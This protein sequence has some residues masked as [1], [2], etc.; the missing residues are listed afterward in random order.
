MKIN[1]LNFKGALLLALL[2]SIAF[3]ALISG[4]IG[5]SHDSLIYLE[6]AQNII[7]GNGFFVNGL[8]MTHYPP[9]YP[10]LLS[11]GKLSELNPFEFSEYVQ[12]LLFGLNII[13]LA[14][15]VYQATMK[16]IYYS[17]LGALFFILSGNVLTVFSYVWSEALFVF[18]MLAGNVFM[19]KYLQKPRVYL[20]I[21]S[22]IIL[23]LTP[24]T[25]YAGFV[26]LI[27]SLCLL[28]VFWGKSIFFRRIPEFILYIVF[29]ILPYSVW[30]ARNRFIGIKERGF[31]PDYISI[32]TLRNIVN[33]I[34][35][36]LFGF[37]F[38]F[39]YKFLLLSLIATLIVISL[40]LICIKLFF[41]LDLNYKIT[42]Y[43]LLLCIISVPV[44]ISFIIFARIFFDHAIPFDY[45]MFFPIYP[46]IIIALLT[47]FYHLTEMLRQ[48]YIKVLIF[49]V[50]VSIFIPGFTNALAY[51]KEVYQFGLGY[52]SIKSE[53]IKALRN[54]KKEIKIYSTSGPAIGLIISREVTSFP[55]KYEFKEKEI[56][57]LPADAYSGKIN[58]LLK[59]CAEGKAV[60]LYLNNFNWRCSIY[61]LPSDV[62]IE[63]GNLDQIKYNDGIILYSKK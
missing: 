39:R 31:N 3:F 53:A 61:F 34:F 30:V 46:Y 18:L 35:S 24:I 51:S 12:S 19:F 41:K 25:R 60:I 13:L 36:Y 50:L 17:V 15:L 56:E 52:N 11:S 38:S 22:A 58:Q 44:Y 26:F 47:A 4:H 48:K 28:C 37:E 43:V 62:M 29:Y 33:T 55:S 16:N 21:L 23:G 45:R 57:A 63:K 14:Y 7:S 20:L 32:Q 59:E 2:L 8:P 27:P 5:V 49:I 10:L 40:V 42:F 54:L 9:L 6:C 1:Y